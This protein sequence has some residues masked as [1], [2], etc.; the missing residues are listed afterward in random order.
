RRGG[1]APPRG[2]RRAGRGAV[3]PRACGGAPLCLGAAGPAEPVQAGLFTADV[4]GDLIELIGRHVEPVRRL[5]PL[6]RRVLNDQVFPNRALDAAA[7]HLLVPP[8]TVL[9]VHHEVAGRELERAA[10][11]APPARPPPP[12]PRPH[13]PAGP[14]RL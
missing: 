6:A 8:D 1:R 13:A 2:S 14:V 12:P 9:L 7:G 11:A 3:R 5:A 10:A 4:P